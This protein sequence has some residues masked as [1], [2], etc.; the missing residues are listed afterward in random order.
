MQ[1]LVQY[2]CSA[3]PAAVLL[4]LRWLLLWL[5]LPSEWRLTGA[6][7]RRRDSYVGWHF[8]GWLFIGLATGG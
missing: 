5:Q 2:R 1:L 3:V 8:S 6:Q 4:T 7:N